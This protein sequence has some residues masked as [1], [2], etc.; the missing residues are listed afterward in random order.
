MLHSLVIM[1]PYRSRKTIN[2]Y[3]KGM[4][5]KAT[6][7]KFSQ[8]QEKRI[9]TLCLNHVK[10]QSHTVTCNELVAMLNKKDFYLC[11]RTLFRIFSRHSIFFGSVLKKNIFSQRDIDKRFAFA[12]A[13]RE[14]PVEFFRELGYL[15]NK[16]FMVTASAESKLYHVKQGIKGAYRKRS[17]GT[18]TFVNSKPNEKL[19]YN[20]GQKNVHVSLLLSYDKG[21]KLV[22]FHSDKWNSHRSRRLF[23]RIGRL[24][25]RA[26]CK[27]LMDNDRVYHSR[28]SV[29]VRT[30]QGIDAFRIPAR[31]PCLNPLDYSVWKYIDDKLRISNHRLMGVT[32]SRQQFLRRLRQ[33]IYRVPRAY[34]RKCIDDMRRRV[35][36]LFQ[37]RGN[38]FRD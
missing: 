12:Q 2:K 27:I 21:V 14:K 36:V 25:N 20:S 31:S 16:T 29:V 32:E 13:Y 24:N 33:I 9:I 37:L 34:V 7:R 18:F 3:T 8:R 10:K 1:Q 11:K 15:D 22:V 28:V 4:P 35:G 23:M 17:T 5:P 6:R 26:N 19:K 30:A 38:V